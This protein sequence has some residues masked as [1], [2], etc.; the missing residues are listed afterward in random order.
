MVYNLKK[1]LHL[2]LE[3]GA[4]RWKRIINTQK[5]PYRLL[6]IILF[7]ARGTAEK[8]LQFQIFSSDLKSL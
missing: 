2:R 6:N 4:V 3:T 5:Q 7:F 8:Y 1:H